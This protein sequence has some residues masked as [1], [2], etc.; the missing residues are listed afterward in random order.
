MSSLLT[1]TS[2]MN[3][4]STLRNINQ[5]LSTTQD[6]I[7]TGLKVQSAK[8]NA[9]YFSISESMKGDSA[10]YSAIDEGLT[11]TKNSLAAAEKGAKSF[12]EL[13]QKFTE[14]MAFSQNG[15]NEVAAPTQ[16]EFKELV[17]QMETIIA[18]STF[19][20]DDLVGASGKIAG[21]DAAKIEGTNGSW[22]F[23][24]AGSDR[25]TAAEVAAADKAGKD[26]ADAVTTAAGALADE[27]ALAAVTDTDDQAKYLAAINAA[28]KEAGTGAMGAFS[29]TAAD[30]TADD[31][32]A[33]NAAILADEKKV[34]S[35]AA[36]SAKLATYTATET[37]KSR[38]AVTGISR[39]GGE[40]STT[41]IT[42]NMVDLKALASGFA[43]LAEQA[44]DTNLASGDFKSVALKASNDLLNS[45][46]SATAN[47]GQS[48]ASV[49]NQQ[50]FLKTLTDT[51]DNGVGAMVDADME[52]EAARLQALQVQQQLATQ[53]LSIA[54]QGPQNLLSLFR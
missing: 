19:N 44:T 38:E 8:D 25:Y 53:S 1:N 27:T 36:S 45:S 28:R 42:V 26:A 13:A 18:Q 50:E 17:K 3:A 6:R 54:N 40:F 23:T 51:L 2:A 30:Y 5:N 41:K 20:G 31:L 34:A 32:A 39:A 11:L 29:T 15:T 22:T 49:E 48:A 37:P 52:E 12:Q 7:G 14:R 4:L 24:A 46:I 10:M 21:K 16:G 33:V 47:L 9:A 43:A 35:D